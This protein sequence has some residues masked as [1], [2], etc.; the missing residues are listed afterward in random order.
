[1][2]LSGF[3][4]L[5]AKIY[6]YWENVCIDQVATIATV[7]LKSIH[8]IYKGFKND[9]SQ[10]SQ[11]FLFFL[12]TCIYIGLDLDLDIALKL[13]PYGGLIG[14]DNSSLDK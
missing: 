13:Q 14:I 5:L 11:R 2:W 8:G 7:D 1:M 4:Q 3:G 12:A 9:Y 10:Y 6:H